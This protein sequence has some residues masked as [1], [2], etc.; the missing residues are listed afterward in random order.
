MKSLENANITEYSI[1]CFIL[2][3]SI[4]YYFILFYSISRAFVDAVTNKTKTFPFRISLFNDVH[5]NK[6]LDL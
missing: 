4:L 1:F 3:Y 6:T 5:Q 2:F